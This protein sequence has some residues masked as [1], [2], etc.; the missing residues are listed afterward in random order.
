MSRVRTHFCTLVAR[1]NGA[2]SRPVRYGMNGTMPATVNSREGSGDTSDALGT[3]VWP[4]SAKCSRKRRRISA[5]C[6]RLYFNLRQFDGGC[7]QEGA[8][9]GPR[10]QLSAASSVVG[11]MAAGEGELGPGRQRCVEPGARAQLRLALGRGGADVGT[12][13]ADG[14]GQLAQ[15]VGE[16]AQDPG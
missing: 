14:L 4:R 8:R 11:G 6:I 10:D 12:E 3:T 9:G 7:R 2:G 13:V 15:A 1:G 5:V 16:R